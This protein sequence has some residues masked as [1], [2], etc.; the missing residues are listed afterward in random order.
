MSFYPSEVISPVPVSGDRSLVLVG[1]NN[2]NLPLRVVGLNPVLFGPPVIKFK[3][4]NPFTPIPISLFTNF[5]NYHLPLPFG[6]AN[7]CL[8]ILFTPTTQ[9]LAPSQQ[10]KISVDVNGQKHTIETSHKELYQ[11]LNIL[12]SR[13]G[14]NLPNFK[15]KDGNS[16]NLQQLMENLRE[17]IIQEDPNYFD[18]HSGNLVQPVP[19]LVVS[20]TPFRL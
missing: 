19:V 10:V 5:N 14:F 4:M 11:R 15:D 3:H 20:K 13:C 12:K 9:N 1:L 16:S 18:T 7:N 17:K 8:R 6:V 2:N